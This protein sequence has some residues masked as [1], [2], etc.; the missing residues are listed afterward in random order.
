MQNL[1]VRLVILDWSELP[2][3]IKIKLD[4]KISS[5]A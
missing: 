4:K 5:A 3:E 1:F 2:S